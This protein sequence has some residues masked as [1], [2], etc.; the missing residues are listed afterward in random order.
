MSVICCGTA[1]LKLLDLV[2]PCFVETVRTDRERTVVMSV[3]ETMNNMMKT[4]KEEVC[5][6]PSHLKEISH[7]IRDVLKKKV[8]E[9][10]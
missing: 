9:N 1:L 4:C 2:L 3:L 6:N 7:L 10:E 8:R 5:R